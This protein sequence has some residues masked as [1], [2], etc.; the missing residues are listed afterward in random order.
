MAN[1]DRP[2]GFKFAKSLSGQAP[3]AMIRFYETDA[4]K[5]NAIFIGDAVTLA[6]D[7]KVEQ[8]ATN[9]VMLGVCVATGFDAIEHGDTGY[10]NADNL[11][12]R[13]LNAAD[14]GVVAVMPAEGNLFEAQ[15]Q[16]G[17]AAVKQGD[18]L[19]IVATA[20]STTTGVS[21][22]ELNTTSTNADCRVVEVNK[23][24]DND[25]ALANARVLVQFRAV[26]HGTSQT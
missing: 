25:I 10:F 19:D 2:N 18:D 15:T 20:G 13:H 5:S 4:A 1:V 7:G 26:E 3:N 8:A 11:G 6:A 16:T 22:M 9:D 23:A 24:P 17:S 21:A 12:K 14:A